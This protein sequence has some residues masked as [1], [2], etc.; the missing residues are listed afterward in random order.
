MLTIYAWNSAPIT[1]TDLS[2]SLLTVGRE[3]HFPI[4]FTSNAHITYNVDITHVKSFADD[5]TDLLYKCHEVYKH[6]ISEHRAL[7]REYRKSQLQNLRKFHEGDYV[8]TNVQIQSK[9]S[10]GTVRKLSYVKRGPYKIIKLWPSGSYTLQN[11]TGTTI[12]K[13]G[14]DLYLCPKELIPFNPINT[15][16]RN[17]SELNKK[18]VS[19]PYEK[20]RIDG[21]SP[22]QP[23]CAPAAY[24]KLEK[25]D[26]IQYPTFPTVEE[27]DNEIDN[28]P[29]SVNPFI[30]SDPTPIQQNNTVPD[31]DS[32]PALPAITQTPLSLSLPALIR[33]HS[34]LYFISHKQPNSERKE[35]KLIQVNLDLS[36]KNRPQCLQD[37]KF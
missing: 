16:D 32:I 31:Q 26:P 36:M 15:S 37:G 5:L 12:K 25:M 10:T 11:S 21:Y 24:A 2:R 20:I 4:D 14:S 27:L 9:Q 23:W 30:P 1:G 17:F 35:W 22:S 33:S 7:H 8:F 29:D 34:K 3:F 13:H 18:M 19:N 28:W 6:L